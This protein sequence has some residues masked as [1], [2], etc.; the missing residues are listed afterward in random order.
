MRDRE[1][2]QEQGRGTERKG[3]T[4]DPKQA[5]GREPS[6]QSPG[7]GSNSRTARSGPEPKSDARPSDP[8][9]PARH[10]S[11]PTLAYQLAPVHLAHT[12]CPTPACP[13]GPAPPNPPPLP[14]SFCPT[15]P[16]LCQDQ[17]LPAV[18][19]VTTSLPH[20]AGAGSSGCT[21]KTTRILYVDYISLKKKKKSN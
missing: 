19:P 4:Q 18:P 9:A 16:S 15:T 11:C 5:P 7:Q 3:D 2:E 12:A 6:A 13:C 17:C 14:S 8:G 10:F 21:P 1:T 20:P